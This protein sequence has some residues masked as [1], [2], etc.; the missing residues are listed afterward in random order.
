MSWSLIAVKRAFRIRRPL[1]SYLTDLFTA[2]RLRSEN[3]SEFYNRIAPRY[4]SLHRGWMAL[5]GR[6]AVAAVKGCVAGALKPG[7]KVLDAGCGTGRVASELVPLIGT[8]R[9]TLLDA[10]PR[11]L[12]AARD[13][14][15]DLQIGDLRALPF[16]NATFDVVMS[17]WAIE[18]LA[19]GR[20]LALSEFRRVLKP[21]GM[22]VYC[23]CAVPR[24][25]K[26]RLLSFFHRKAIGAFFHG[27]FLTAHEAVP[28]ELQ[29]A[30]LL[31]FHSGLSQV[32]IYRDH[33]NEQGHEAAKMA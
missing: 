26:T 32:V 31:R 25:A 24:S 15:V 4:D 33:G 30:K 12:D 28:A 18:T 20:E 22:I 14:P 2:V 6:L 17:T 16:G 10:A 21:G 5:G 19:S 3:P 9:F 27:R 23:T 29:G 7:A 11:M 8:A 13:L 1:L